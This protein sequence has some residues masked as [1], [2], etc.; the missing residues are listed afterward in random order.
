MDQRLLAASQMIT[1]GMPVADIGT[2]HV[3]LPLY[4]VGSGLVPSVIATEC[5]DR[6]YQR[7]AQIVRM[8]DHLSQ[9]TLRQGDGLQVLKPGEVDTVVIMGMGGDTIAEIVS[10]DWNHAESFSRFVLQ[11]MTRA[12]TVRRLLVGRGWQIQDEKVVRQRER[13]FVLI[14]FEPDRNTRQLSALE[15][16][17]GPLLLHS[18]GPVEQAYRQACLNKMK[19]LH[20]RLMFSRS[21]ESQEKAMY[22]LDMFQEL[23]GI[24]NGNIC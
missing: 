23:E 12:G 24:V 17:V 8:T 3:Q 14:Q 4:L 20:R 15:A 18:I 7:A 9:I 19:I 10:R 1:T 5:G 13:F 21:A 11:P 16:E 22:F 6:P 2:D